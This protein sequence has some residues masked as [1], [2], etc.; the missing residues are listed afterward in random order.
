MNEKKWNIPFFELFF[1]IHGFR[2]LIITV[3]Q[4]FLSCFSSLI[5]IPD[6]NGVVKDKKGLL[7]SQQY[8][9]FE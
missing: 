8:D 9:L 1:E 6:E 2:I 3:F 7:V 5:L 4:N